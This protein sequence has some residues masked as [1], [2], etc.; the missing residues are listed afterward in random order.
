MATT[1]NKPMTN[2]EIYEQK[3]YEE[4]VNAKIDKMRGK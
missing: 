1:T 3:A 2:A 4:A